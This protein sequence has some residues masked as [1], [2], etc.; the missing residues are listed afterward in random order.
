METNQLIHLLLKNK[1]TM[2]VFCG[3]LPIDHLPQK[4]V[5]KP[6]S[7]IVNTHNSKLPGEHWFAIFVPKRGYI[8]YFDSY[9]KKPINKEV[10][11]FIKTNGK[12]YI[13]NK[14]CIQ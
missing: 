12:K 10:Y 5:R 11:N 13:Y 9:G 3:V 2:N 14:K 4:Q 1:Y 6:C 8:E 7:F